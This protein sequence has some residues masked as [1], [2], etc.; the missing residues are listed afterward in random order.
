MPWLWHGPATI[1]HATSV[2]SSLE[3]MISRSHAFTP[4]LIYSFS[5]LPQ[6]RNLFSE[7]V[8]FGD[9]SFE[10]RCSLSVVENGRPVRGLCTETASAPL[11]GAK[12]CV[13]GSCGSRVGST[14][15]R[16]LRALKCSK[17]FLKLI[18]RALG[19]YYSLKYFLQNPGPKTNRY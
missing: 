7:A 16:L 1:T 13:K 5:C 12:L 8:P 4:Y 15:R 9:Q 3:R 17:Q 18:H 14:A 10:L 6:G 11:S 19:V 2:S